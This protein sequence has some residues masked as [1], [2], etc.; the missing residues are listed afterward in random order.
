MLIIVVSLLK[1]QNLCLTAF[2][3][4]LKISSLLLKLNYPRWKSYSPI[5]IFTVRDS[6]TTGSFTEKWGSHIFRAAAN[7]IRNKERGTKNHRMGVIVQR[8]NKLKTLR[9]NAKY[10]KNDQPLA[11]SV[12]TS[13][14][15][16]FC[17]CLWFQ[18][19]SMGF[20]KAAGWNCDSVCIHSSPL[21]WQS[22]TAK[23][24]TCSQMNSLYHYS[25]CE[26]IFLDL[27]N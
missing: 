9:G 26:S 15:G 20:G 1:P 21:W 12:P 4:T 17:E 23:G 24:Y 6:L 27:N 18:G 8:E 16:C 22:Q 11:I 25:R 13:K 14:L 10:R 2:M 7:Q 19:V 5:L 3:H